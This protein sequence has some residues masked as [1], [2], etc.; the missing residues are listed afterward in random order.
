MYLKWLKSE[1]QID[2]CIPTFLAALFPIAKSGDNPSVHPQRMD[3]QNVTYTY[4]GILF[5]PK[6]GWNSD[7]SINIEHIMLSDISHTQKN[8][9]CVIPLT[10]KM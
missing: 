1:T 6:N 9:Y 2:I 10:F 7:T 8:G 3:K 4:N 5:M